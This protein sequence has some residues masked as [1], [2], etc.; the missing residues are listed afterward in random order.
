MQLSNFRSNKQVAIKEA[1][2][3]FFVIVVVVGVDS[4]F[5]QPEIRSLMRLVSEPG[6]PCQLL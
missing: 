1:T 2:I 6:Y 5:D 3:S 4:M